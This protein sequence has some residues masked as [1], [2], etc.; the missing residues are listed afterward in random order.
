MSWRIRNHGFEMTLSSKLPGLVEEQLPGWLP[1]WLSGHGLT[2]ADIGSWAI[3]PGG[4]KILTAAENAL[5]I[6]PAETQV[7]RDVLS[8][9]GNVS[10][11]T[12]LLLIDRLRRAAA[13]GPCVT[14]GFGP[15]ICGEVALWR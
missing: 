12:V 6:D 5:G 13:P 11:A 14:L 7:S 1:E 8:E 3:H 4:P 2:L 10:S 15:G 9:H